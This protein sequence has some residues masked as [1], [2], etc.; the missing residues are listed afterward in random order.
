[1]AR[2]LMMPLVRGKTAGL[3]WVR[4]LKVGQDALA[5]IAELA[6]IAAAASASEVALAWETLLA[7]FRSSARRRAGALS[8]TGTSCTGSPTASSSCPEPRRLGVG[9]PCL[10]PAPAPQPGGEPAPPIRAAVNFSF[11]S[12][13][14]DHS[15]SFGVTVVLKALA[16]QPHAQGY[17]CPYA[18]DWGADKTRWGLSIDPTEHAAL[19]EAL[20]ICPD[21]PITVTLAR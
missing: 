15:D 4:P 13:E 21:Q 7:S 10:R 9:R 8:G 3:I 20:S 16:W 6:N 14:L 5:G 18:T 12:I 11:A 1:M 2:P 17:R 19:S